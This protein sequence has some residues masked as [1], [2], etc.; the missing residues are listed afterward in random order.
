MVYRYNL[1]YVYDSEIDTRGLVYPRALMQMLLGLYFAEVCLIGLFS[2]RGAFVPVVLTV[3]L[4]VVTAL[5]HTSLVEALGPLLSSLPKSLTVEE[6]RHLLSTTSADHPERPTEY[7]AHWEH[8][9]FDFEKDGEERTEG[10]SR[11]LEGADSALDTLGDGF[12]SMVRKRVQK[13][14][15]ELN[16]GLGALSAFWMRWIS[17]DPSQ[18]SNFLLRWLH[19]EVYSAYTILRRMVPSDLPEPAYSEEVE[20]DIYYPPS[21]AA[22]P[23]TLWIPRDVGGIS[24]QEVEHC[25][26]VIPVTDE[27]VS[28]DEAGRMK[29]NLEEQRLVFDV[30]RL[31]Y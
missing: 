14:L 12:K 11:A 24:G 17:P 27:Y 8:P 9:P 1:I 18:R 5:V 22:K 21:F 15:P 29:I 6:D 4:L 31:R 23:P 26:K 16:V 2:L 13:D 10:Q 28:I 7:P 30:E 3:V 25:G 19:P 20:R